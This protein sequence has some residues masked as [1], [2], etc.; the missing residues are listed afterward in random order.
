MRYLRPV[1]PW[2]LYPSVGKDIVPSGC[3]GVAQRL[4]ERSEAIYSFVVVFYHG[5]KIPSG[6]GSKRRFDYLLG[7]STFL[8]KNSCVLCRSNHL[9]GVPACVKNWRAHTSICV[10]AGGRAIRSN[11]WEG[12][13]RFVLSWIPTHFCCY[14]SRS[15]G[16]QIKYC[17]CK[18]FKKIAHHTKIIVV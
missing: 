8:C 6:S 11:G 9:L 18:S 5:A 12:I 16:S 4:A 13:F 10:N 17:M 2:I 7:V 1:K 14:P 3:V 15:V